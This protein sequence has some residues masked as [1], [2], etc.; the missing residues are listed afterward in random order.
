MP[1]KREARFTLSPITVQDKRR[2]EPIVPTF[3][4]PVFKPNPNRNGGAPRRL[5][6]RVQLRQAA[7]HAQRAG[8]TARCVIFLRR[9]PAPESHNGVA[10]E[11]I[12]RAVGGEKNFGHLFK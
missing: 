5:P 8:A 7:G 2:A 6:F 1:S 4:T 10:D 3:T 9:R 12:E 11:F